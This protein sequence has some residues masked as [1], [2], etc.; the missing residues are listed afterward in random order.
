MNRFLN[1]LANNIN[2]FILIGG[3]V[4]IL[5]IAR[6]TGILISHKKS[7]KEILHRKSIKAS[8]NKKTFALNE[9]EVEETVTPDTVRE[10]ERKFNQTCSRCNIY[11]QLISL[12]PLLGILGTVLGLM[13]QVNAQE[14]EKMIVSLDVALASTFWG[15][16]F[17]IGLKFIVILAPDRIIDDVEIMLEDYDKKFNN[18]LALK[19][20]TEE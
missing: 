14:I 16:L 2:V 6:D 15:L 1:F 10:Y 20:I 17:S 12:F 13:L 19:N 11:N 7:I 4:L 3:V 5:F 9:E 18:A 8:I